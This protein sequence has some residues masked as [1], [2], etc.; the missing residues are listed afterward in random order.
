M[1]GLII[2]VKV[3]FDVKKSIWKG[4][5]RLPVKSRDV[6]TSYDSISKNSDVLYVFTLNT[7]HSY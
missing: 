6:D 3:D 5:L 4:T 2:D 7:Y 1:K